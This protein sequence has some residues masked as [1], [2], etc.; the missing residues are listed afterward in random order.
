MLVDPFPRVEIDQLCDVVHRV[1]LEDLDLRVFDELTSKDI[2]FIDNSHRSF[3][4]SDV[5]VFFLEVL[6]RLPKGLRTVSTTSFFL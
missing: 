2:V 4:N 6:G 1:G 5:T 3:P